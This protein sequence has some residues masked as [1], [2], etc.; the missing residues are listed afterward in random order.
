MGPFLCNAGFQVLWAK[1]LALA[2][3]RNENRKAAMR[4]CAIYEWVEQFMKDVVRIVL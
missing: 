1:T 3:L 2:D 4:E